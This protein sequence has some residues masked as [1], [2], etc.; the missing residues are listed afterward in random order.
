MTVLDVLLQPNIRQ[1]FIEECEDLLIF[2]ATYDHIIEN[3]RAVA[4]EAHESNTIAEASVRQLLDTAL[5]A[6][7]KELSHEGLPV[8][9]PEENLEERL[10]KQFD[11]WIRRFIE[12]P[13]HAEALKSIEAWKKQVFPRLSETLFA[14]VTFIVQ[15]LLPRL[16][17]AESGG[18]RY[19]GRIQPKNI[20]IKDFWNRLS[21]AYRDLLIQDLLGRAKRKQVVKSRMLIDRF[22]GNFHELDANLMSAD[23]ADFPGFRLSI[24]EA[25]SRKVTPCGLITGIGR[26]NGVPG[27]PLMGVAVSN[28]EFQAGAFDMA[29]AEK[30][31]ALLRECMQRD[32][33]SSASSP[34]AACRP[35]KAPSS[36]CPSSTTASPALSAT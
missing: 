23:P 25:L 19:D 18:K 35:R 16:D 22:F 11:D 34:P 32:L 15:S 9:A 21:I 24:E 7:A 1:T 31:C 17:T 6:A 14:I 30:F 13:D 33:P 12:F 10:R 27:R 28:L 29:S 8:R 2:D 4:R 36:P 5:R 26:L 20:G 3:L